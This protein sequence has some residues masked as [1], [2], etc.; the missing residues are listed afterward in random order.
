MRLSP[1]SPG[2]TEVRLIDFDHAVTRDQSQSD[3]EW[4]EAVNQE[5]AA[6]QQLLAISDRVR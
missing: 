6:V 2:H 3:E 4:A 5:R 1:A